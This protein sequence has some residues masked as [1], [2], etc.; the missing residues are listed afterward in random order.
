MLK[1]SSTVNECKP[2]VVGAGVVA[3]VVAPAWV[4]YLAVLW[5]ATCSA[6]FMAG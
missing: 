1:L 4:H 5:G 2:L 3:K 6:V